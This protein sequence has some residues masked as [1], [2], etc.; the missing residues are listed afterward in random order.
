M[1]ENNTELLAEQIIERGVV[2]KLEGVKKE[3]SVQII[4]KAQKHYN[5]DMEAFLNGDEFSFL[6]DFILIH[7]HYHKETDS[8][9]NKFLPRYS[10]P[11]K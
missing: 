2:V 9:D 7:K 4:L 11:K 6:H 8:F 5:L 1:L 3:E 10:R